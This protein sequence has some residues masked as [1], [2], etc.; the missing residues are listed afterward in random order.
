MSNAIVFPDAESAMQAC[1]VG[2]VFERVSHGWKVKFVDGGTQVFVEGPTIS[3][4]LASH[5]AQIV[6]PVK[7]I[8]QGVVEVE[9][10]EAVAEVVTVTAADVGSI[11]SVLGTFG[12]GDE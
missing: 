8:P 11:E 12:E 9:A 3:D 10:V 2:S 4:A 1:G 6:H 5:G 7:E